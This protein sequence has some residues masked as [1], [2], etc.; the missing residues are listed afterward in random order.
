VANGADRKIWVWTEVAGDAPHRQSLELLTPARALGRAEAVVLSPAAQP[1]L[2][3]LGRHGA[4]VVHH[5]DD[6]RYAQYLTDP[7]VATLAALIA[8]EQPTLILFPS[9]PGARDVLAR[10]VARLGVGI[11]TNAI[12]LRYDGGEL[13]VT[14]P[15][16]AET[17]G[18]LTL[19]GPGPHLVQIRPKAFAAEEGGGSAELR[20]VSIA[21][22]D[23][24]CRVRVVETVEEPSQGPNLEDAAIIVSGGRGLGKPE[25]YHLIE[26]LAK[27]LH[28]APGAT[29]AIVD[30]G[31]VPYSHQVGQTG[32]TVKPTV[33]IACGISGAI[34][35]V[36]GMP[37]ASTSSPSIAT[38]TLPSSS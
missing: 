24:T 38:R 20:P 2:E 7:Q 16:G 5:A 26:D 30:A 33:Y 13:R 25:N 11:V 1:A 12:D 9:T 37:P 31:W 10:L 22:D 23:A 32:R 6:P 4:A 18:T 34:Q 27:Q 19:A 8:Q 15:Y 21:I 29:R 14:V 17:I 3:V 28:G 35:H 36:A